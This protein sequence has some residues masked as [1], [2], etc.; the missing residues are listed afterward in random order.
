MKTTTDKSIIEDMLVIIKYAVKLGSANG[1]KGVE[2]FN[3]LKNKSAS[4]SYLL[5]KIKYIKTED[6]RFW[7]IQ[8]L[9]NK[10]LDDV[11]SNLYSDKVKELIEYLQTVKL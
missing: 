3:N 2:S 11:H 5:Q 4:A 7:N 9:T 1:F 6:F 10:A 8:E